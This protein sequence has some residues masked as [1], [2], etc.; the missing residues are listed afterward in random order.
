MI[1]AG[2]ITARSG[3]QPPHH[4]TCA[5]SR[6]NIGYLFEPTNDKRVVEIDKI[7]PKDPLFFGY[8]VGYMAVTH[9]KTMYL[10]TRD[11]QWLSPAMIDLLSSL[12]NHKIDAKRAG[13][14]VI[15]LSPAE[16]TALASKPVR[17]ERCIV[18][19]KNQPFPAL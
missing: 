7:V 9:D 5:D 12:T 8:V 11:S 19:P 10:T 14:T 6:V 4:G 18:W 1:L 15:R 13:F 3:W 17:L 16:R 2:A